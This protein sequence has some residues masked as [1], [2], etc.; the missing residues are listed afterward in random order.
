MR[1]SLMFSALLLVAVVEAQEAGIKPIASIMQLHEAMISPASD[2]IFE[3]GRQ[4][5]R[6]D[7]EW[8]A[9]R[10]HAVILAESGN[11]LMIEG[12]AK[13]QQDWM[14]MSAELVNAAAEALR[15]TETKQIDRVL[16]AGDRIALIC[17]ACHEPYR[18]GGRKMGPP[19]R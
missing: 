16:A 9:L 1:I 8:A 2:A 6:D 17:E 19:V 10:N 15:A 7:K 13:D 12:R 3:V 14:K 18:D 5:P 4:T 11:L